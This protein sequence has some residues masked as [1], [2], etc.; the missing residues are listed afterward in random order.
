V[1]VIR[2]VADFGE[3]VKVVLKRGGDGKSGRWVGEELWGLLGFVALCVF[4]CISVV[5][6]EGAYVRDYMGLGLSIV[7]Q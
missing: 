5:V 7:V 4:W 6:V 3:L 1:V 2:L